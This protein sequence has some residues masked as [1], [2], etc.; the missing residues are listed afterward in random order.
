MS[1]LL[2]DVWYFK[3]YECLKILF[4]QFTFLKRLNKYWCLKKHNAMQTYGGVAVCLHSFLNL[5][6]RQRWVISFMPL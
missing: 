4:M 3:N 6:T 2:Q 5:G 1:L